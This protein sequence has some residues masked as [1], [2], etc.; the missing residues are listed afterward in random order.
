[1]KRLIDENKT[2]YK[3]NLHCH[4]VH[5]DGQWT[6]EQIKEEYKKRGYSVVAVTDHEHLLNHSAL[7]DD[8]FLF[9]T[10]YE[11]YVRNLPFDYLNDPQSHI[12][13]YS[14]TPENKLLYYTPSITKYIPKAEL[15]NLQYHKL[16][17]NREYNVEFIRQTVQDAK[18]KGFLVCHN[19]PT[20]SFENEDFASAYDGCFAM[21][22]YNHGSYQFGYN[23]Y[24]Q[25]YYDYQINRGLQMAV[26]ASDDNHN[27][28][29]DPYGDSFGGITYILADH[30]EYG[31]IINALENKDFYATTGPK[32]FSLSVEDGKLNVKTSDAE[33]IVF[34]TNNHH[35]KVVSSKNGEV[36]TQAEFTAT[37]KDSWVRVEVVDFKGKRA[38]TRAFFKKELFE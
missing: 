30:L 33:R 18:E 17:V 7:S 4:S 37:T 21:E 22:I 28:E 34:I 19:H 6:V 31:S 24:N 26:I 13:L 12:N 20:W 23:E 35:R 11:M 25:H 10:G 1:M 5:S 9:I 15:E 38:F 8:E 32:I 14:K 2:Q 3:A 36:I 16:V 29:D 27:F